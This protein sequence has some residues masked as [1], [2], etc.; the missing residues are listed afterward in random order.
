MVDPQ[1]EEAVV[2]GTFLGGLAL[3]GLSKQGKITIPGWLQWGG[4][5]A[6]SVAGGYAMYGDM[7]IFG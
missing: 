1:I 5:L 7:K 2:K 6:A 4:I 3:W